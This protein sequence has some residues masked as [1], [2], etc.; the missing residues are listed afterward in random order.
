MGELLIKNGTDSDALAVLATLE[1]Q[2]VLS[3]YI[4]AEEQFQ[5]TGI[6]DNSYQLYFHKGSLWDSG[7][8][9]FANNPTYQRFEDLLPFET[10]ATQYTGYEVTLF[11]VA[12]GS[13]ATENV[14]PGQFP[15]P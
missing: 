11:G 8:N 13:A 9:R 14:D 12:G 7:S 6:P 10:T 3:A 4:R 5:M 1:D 2:A 15:G